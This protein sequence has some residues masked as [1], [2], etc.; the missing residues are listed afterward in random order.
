MV[1]R[2]TVTLQQHSAADIVQNNLWYR[3]T[4]YHCNSTVLL[5]LFKII[6]DTEVHGNTATAQC[7]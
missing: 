4:Q 6:Y 5:M 1:Q 3:G 7:C 2:Y